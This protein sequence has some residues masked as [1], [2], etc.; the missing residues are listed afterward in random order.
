VAIAVPSAA[1][2]ETAARSSIRTYTAQ[3]RLDITGIGAEKGFST[4]LSGSGEAVVSPHLAL[5]ASTRSDFTFGKDHDSE[6]AQLYL[7]GNRGYTRDHGARKWT[8]SK[9]SGGELRLIRRF[10]SPVAD[11][12]AFEK[13]ATSGG[14][15]PGTTG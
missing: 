9:V 3:F 6:S 12:A 7:V 11:Q 1:S 2:A 8:E 5:R 13:L 10:I 15:V 4:R 14:S